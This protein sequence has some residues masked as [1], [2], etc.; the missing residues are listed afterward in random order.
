MGSGPSELLEIFMKNSLIGGAVA[1]LLGPLAVAQT[2]LIGSDPSVRNGGLEDAP[3]GAGTSF[4]VVPFWDS[5]FAPEGQ[6][7]AN[8]GILSTGNPRTGARRIGVNGF[9]E[10]VPASIYPRLHAAQVIPAAEWT[11]AEGDVFTFTAHVR[12]GFNF[13]VGTDSV[14]LLLHVVDA[15]AGAPAPTT[16]GNADRM[17]SEVAPA[18][19]ISATSYSAFTATSAPVPSGSP[20]IGQAVQAR[21]LVS[22]DR[23]EFALVDDI[24]LVGFRSGM[25]DSPP[26]LVASFQAEGTPDNEVAAGS[27][28][29]ADGGL[30]YA[31]GF[32]EGQAFETAAGGVTLPFAPQGAFSAAL[33]IKTS[34]SGP[35]GASLRWDDGAAILDGSVSAGNGFGLS[36]RGPL[37]VVGFGDTLLTSQTL[38]A[39][40]RWHHVA[41]SR[42]VLGE[43]K[44]YLDGQLEDV[45]MASQSLAAMPDL[46]LGASRLG[47]RAFAGLIDDVQLFDGILQLEDI[48]A[49]RVS[50]G[51]SDGDGFSDVAELAAGTD[52]GDRNDFP[53]VSAIAKEG[54]EVRAQV[55]GRRARQYQ[56]VRHL[57]LTDET[58][59]SVPDLVPALELDAEVELVDSDAPADRAFYRVRSEEGTP[60]KPNILFI[61]ADDQGFA[62]LSAYPNA[63]PDIAT[64]NLD[65]IAAAGTLFTQAY[66]TSPVCSPSRAGYL[67]GRYQ[68]EW[69]PTGGWSPRLPSDVKHIAE[70]LKEAGYDTRMI[71]KNDFG[72]ATGSI[73]N[74]DHP[75]NHGFD[76][77]FGFNAH[78]HDFWLSSQDI[79]DSVRPAWPT[80]ASA[81]LG[82][83][84]N[85]ELPG[86]FETTQDDEWQTSLFTDRAIEYLEGREGDPDPFFLYLSHASVHA[87]IHQV[88]ES[89]LV[90][91]GV[92][93][94]PIYDPATDTATN[95]ASYSTYYYRYSRPKPQDANGM[96]EDGDMRKYYR[97][98]LK[99]YDDEMGRLLD[100][101]ASEGLAENTLIVYF[102]DNG[103]EALTGANNQPLSGSKYNVFEGGIRTPLLLSWP[104]RIPAGQ[105]YEHVT[106]VLDIVPTL[107]D[108]AGVENAAPLS[109]HSLLEPVQANAP[110][111]PGDR[112]LF[113]RFTNQW[114]IRRGD[115]KLV[116]GRKGLADKATSQ[117]TFNDAALGK[118]SLF[119]LA[120]DPGEMNDLSTSTDPAIQ[121]I[122]ADLQTRFDAWNASNQ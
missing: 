107:L 55:E 20:W 117:I 34:A 60:E 56:L 30:A 51:D 48:A 91:E 7:G 14:Q 6:S 39:D 84:I 42:S 46:K 38:V 40:G 11:I 62:D 67:T 29:V 109:G 76:S 15:V 103:G 95:P 21:I 89:Y 116:L 50:A 58:P 86:S 37:A 120:A 82:K 12:A 111:I 87:L 17:L 10:T 3:T 23:D 54:S 35:E 106:S 79:T 105:T 97:A 83:Y 31:G 2:V 41:F 72:Q 65:R 100:V 43:A 69:D 61:V 32:G 16:A 90:E 33:W 1:F 8:T 73:N 74:R 101:L 99:A 71:G 94:L 108:V 102:S 78:A 66:V 81:H 64:P 25:L 80:D 93:V 28:G 59:E 88:P 122:Q 68:N 114:A 70:Y 26:S 92:P 63:R 96:I 98:H 110:V 13:D 115:W 49:I 22:G 113:W 27:P 77:F 4:E 5:Y 52:W 24:S 19:A 118:I 18:G 45:E 112:T 53:Q 75:T 121:A 9:R 85:T 47:G 57:D 44:L 119:N 36:L 104:G